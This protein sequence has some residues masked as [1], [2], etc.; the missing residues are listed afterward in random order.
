MPASI[1]INQDQLVIEITGPDKLWALRSR[2]DI[3]LANVVAVEPAAE[4]AHRWLHGMRLGG[5]TS[6]R[7]SQQDGSTRTGSGASGTCMT[8]TMRSR[9]SCAIS[10]TR[11]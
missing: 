2:L 6:R 9:S 3:P 8:Q 5:T 11:G 10:A 1:D 4:E 7:S